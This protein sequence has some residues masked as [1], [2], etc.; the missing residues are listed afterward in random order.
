[1]KHL[2]KLAFLLLALILPATATAYDFE[3]NGI[4][5]NILNNNEVEVTYR[6]QHEYLYSDDYSGSVTIPPSV[7]YNGKTYSV[8]SIGLGAFSDCLDLTSVKIPNSVTTICNYAFGSC[9]GLTSINIPNSVTSI[10]NGAFGDCWNLSSVTIGNSVIFIGYRAFDA[11]RNLTTINIPNSVTTIGDEAFYCCNGLNEVYSYITDL[12]S[13]SIGSDVFDSTANYGDRT[14]RVPAGTSAAYQADTKWSQY[15]GSIVEMGNVLVSSIELNKNSVEITEGGALQLHTIVLPTNAANKSVNWASSD[16]T[17]ATVNNNGLVT[18]I[19]SGV[20]TI[21]AMTTDGSNLSASCT[22]NVNSSDDFASGEWAF[23][24]DGTPAMVGQTT[25]DH[26]FVRMDYADSGTTCTYDNVVSFKSGDIQT[27]WFWLDDDEIY[28]NDK[29]QALTPIAYNNSGDLYNEITFNS[30]QCDIYLPLNFKIVGIPN[31][32]NNTVFLQSPKL[33]ECFTEV[34]DLFLPN[35]STLLN[36]F[37]SANKFWEDYTPYYVQGPRLPD[38]SD[39]S[40]AEKETKIIDGIEYRIYTVVVSSVREYGTHLSA[41]NAS[42]YRSHGALK[43]NDGAVFGIHVQKQDNTTAEGRQPDI[44]LANQEFGVRECLIAGW[45]PNEYRFIYGEGGNNESQRFQYYNRVALYGSKGI[46]NVLA[47][48]ISLSKT[49]EE[50]NVGNTLQLTATILPENATNKTVNWASSAPTVATVDNNGMVTAVAPGVATITAMTTDGSNLSAS[51]TLTVKQNIVLATSVSLNSTSANL[52]NGG[53]IQLIETVLPSNTTNKTVVWTTSNSSVAIVSSNGLVTAISPGVATITATTT[54]GSNLSS[55]CTITVEPAIEFADANVKALC[56]QNWDT[57]GDGELSI[58]EA[59]TV[60]SLNNVFKNN[61]TITSFD[62]LEYFTGLTSIGNSAFSGC[63][64][65]TSITIPA[66]VTVIDNQ[67]FYEC[68]SL[69]SITIPNSVTTIGSKA[70]AVCKKITDVVIPNHVTSIGNAAFTSCTSLINVTIPSSVTTIGSSAFYGCSSLANVNIPSSIEVISNYT[71]ADCISLTSINI[72]NSIT[73][74]GDNA[75]RDCTGLLQADIPNSVTSIGSSAFSGCSSL[76]ELTIPSSVSTIGNYAFYGCQGLNSIEIP[77]S[78]T[79]IGAYA[80]QGCSSLTVLFFNAISCSYLTTYV[81]E[82][83]F[84]SLN[85]SEIHIGNGVESL[86]NGFA[87]GL[88]NLTS[89]TIPNSVTTIGNYA[90][91]G[92]SGL[93]SLSLTESVDFIGNQAFNNVPSLE[94]VTCAAETPPSWSNIAMFTTNVYNHSP[95]Y[96][97]MGSVNAYKADQSWGQ[98]STIIGIGTVDVVLATSISLNQSQMNLL[99]CGS[100]QLVAT[101]LPESTTNKIV[102]WASSSPNVASVDDNGVVTAIAV[103]TAIITATTTDGSNLSASCV[104]TVV[105]DLSNYDNY[106]S[107]SD[108]EAFHGDT[109]VVPVKMFNEASVIS[110]QT[111]IFLPEGLELLQEDGEFIIDPSERM[112]RT[113]SIMSNQLPDGSIRVLCYSSNYKPFT[114]NSGDDLFYLTVKV[115]DNAE[116]NYTIQLKNTLLTNS[117][118]VDMPAPDVAATVN[119]KAYILGDA[120]NSGLVTVGDVVTTAQYVLLLNPQPFNFEAADVN[121]DGNITVGDVS[122]IAWMVLNPGATAP[123]RAPALLNSGDRMSGEGISL[124]PGETRRVS[125]ALDNVMDYSAFQLD[126]SLPEGMTASNFQLTDR[127]GSHAFDVNTLGDGKFRALCYSP[128]LTAISGHEG[129][130]LTFDVTANAAVTGAIT[131]DGI[132]LVTTACE[133]VRLNGFAI[134]VNS[135]S[136]VNEQIAGK[137]VARVDYYNLAGQQID[138]PEAGV[139]LVVT[140]YTDGTRTTAKVIK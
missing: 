7:T 52:A 8:T 9:K 80:F 75:F 68:S 33:P 28:L 77:T 5:Y 133:S 89:I 86:P 109:I 137:T 58:N 34:G 62:E 123:R 87:Y 4:Y 1:M 134:D 2:I 124:M 59:A 105:E 103:G 106:L 90:F 38:V 55:F 48:S 73:L 100:S 61:T 29:V 72:P 95:L 112:T 26:L 138:R 94:A 47:S 101:V 20:A 46:D 53:M 63:I 93:T 51:C 76:T 74:I 71:F 6:E 128:A 12:S 92:C 120:N 22:I 113:H 23:V 21:T 66:T 45:T 43:K 39:F 64:R 60:T 84:Y 85:I 54:D 91:Y 118:F 135:T 56:V 115:A 88:E 96:V 110:F 35:N 10:G 70:F 3:V 131:V 16:P 50:M 78:I 114:G 17:V 13:V 97:P 130:L 126:L 116:G 83:P 99:L 132:E 79:S 98:F 11:C 108:G 41:T 19:A 119:V 14:L 125:I 139:T 24:A 121:F 31:N 65:M 18:A 30:F 117:D 32:K 127:A 136:G 69:T 25:N 40:F 44:I 140:T 107:M 57:N 42:A 49:N 104:V 67:A 15:F 81:K 102:S 111:D 27:I 122:R 82:L 37:R 129:A 36:Q